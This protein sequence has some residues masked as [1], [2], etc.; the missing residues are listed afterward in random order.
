MCHQLAY[1]VFLSEMTYDSD[2]IIT[3]L[4]SPRSRSWGKQQ[5]V[6]TQT[7]LPKC[8]DSILLIF[9]RWF[10][11]LENQITVINSLPSRYVRPFC[12]ISRSLIVCLGGVLRPTREFFTHMETSPLP[13]KG[14]KFWP[15]LSTH[16]HWAVR[17]LLR[18]TPTVKRANP[19]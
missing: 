5:P 11:E 4:T 3:T 14:F 7:P 10:K 17:F 1:Y 8:I 12:N 18:D 16:G 13:M 19:W 6:L 2:D 9:P 15:M